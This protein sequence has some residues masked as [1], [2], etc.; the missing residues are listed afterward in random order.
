M[1]D[2]I[3]TMTVSPVQLSECSML[4]ST[5]LDKL[6]FERIYRQH[7]SSLY[8]YAFNVLQEN[9]LCED[10]VQEV[11]MDLWRRRQDVHISDLRSYLRQSVKYQ[12]FSHFRESRY[13]KQLLMEFD[14][15]H[16]ECGI[17]E[18]FEAQELEAQIKDAISQ[19][20]KRRRIVFDMSRNEGLSNKE[21]SKKLD[22]SLQTVKNQISES[23]RFIRKSLNNS[24]LLF[25]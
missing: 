17:D 24:Y 19:L 6:S 9:E 23:L 13:K 14:L 21:I 2:R 12:I 8:S 1:D 16:T 3:T 10:I 5:E 20:P 25:F 11:F 4:H 22:I 18:S 7:W 15:V